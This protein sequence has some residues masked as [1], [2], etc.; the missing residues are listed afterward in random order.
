MKHRNLLPFVL[1]TCCLLLVGCK[2]R[3]AF[4]VVDAETNAP[5]TKTLVDHYS[6]FEF[7]DEN[8]GDPYLKATNPLNEPGWIEVKKPKKGDTYTFRISGYEDVRVRMTKP[9]ELAE[10]LVLGGPN[11]Q[12][13][14]KLEEYEDDGQDKVTTFLVPLNKN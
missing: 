3:A 13:W 1:L 7:P 6:L 9:G 2:K 4:L 8:A 12:E 11:I 14:V 10:K 5:L